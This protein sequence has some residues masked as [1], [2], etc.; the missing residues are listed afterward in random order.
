MNS[1]RSGPTAK[2]ASSGSSKKSQSKKVTETSFRRE[3]IQ[4]RFFSNS[5]WRKY[6][7]R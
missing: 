6:R 7:P 1:R 4:T 5:T 2:M 3:R